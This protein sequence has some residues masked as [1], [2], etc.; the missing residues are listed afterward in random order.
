MRMVTEYM[1]EIQHDLAIFTNLNWEWTQHE[2]PEIAQTLWQEEAQ[3]R[4][5]MNLPRNL[6]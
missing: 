2:C 5:S 1:I 4:E 6:V 3:P